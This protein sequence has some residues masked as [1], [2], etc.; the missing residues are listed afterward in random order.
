MRKL[1]VVVSVVLLTGIVS[2]VFA[3]EAQKPEAIAEKMAFKFARGVTNFASAIVEL[4]KQSYLTVRDRGQ[5]GYVI[6]PLKGIGMT[7][8][9]GF[10][11]ITEAI[12]FMVPQPG[13][14]D[15]MMEPEY[16]WQGWEELR[17]EPQKA[18]AE[19]AAEPP[20]GK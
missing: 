7:F 12:F 14:Y 3:A 11:G 20:A 19:A 1:A 2:P 17:P 10:I 8:Y 15:P 16:V 6:G 18:A 5:V 9:R 13:Y 4:P